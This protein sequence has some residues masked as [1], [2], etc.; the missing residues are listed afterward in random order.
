MAKN[1]RPLPEGTFGTHY[2]V[3]YH[4]FES[5]KKPANTRA[6]FMLRDPRDIV[7]SWYFSARYSHPFISV[8]PEMRIQL[9]K[10]DFK[11]GLKYIID[12]VES[13]GTF[14]AQLSWL[15]A[16]NESEQIKIFRYE[17]LADNSSVF[18]RNLFR[19]LEID[20]PESELIS[21][22]EKYSFESINRGR[23]QGAEDIYKHDRKGMPG[24]WRNYFDEDI[25]SYFRKKTGN[26]IELL[27]YE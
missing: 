10:M 7:V 9:E 21:L 17:D 14:E 8:I 26:L 13:F 27:G 15:D 19:F 24:D 22:A 23:K 4:T 5:I 20:I 18:M 25:D 11:T 1:I 2:Y 6:F 16:G 3:D 12:K